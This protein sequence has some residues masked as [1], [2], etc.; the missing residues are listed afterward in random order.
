MAKAQDVFQAITD[1]LIADIEAGAADGTWRMPW[2]AMA[3]MGAPM[4][5]TGRPYR[6]SNA[7]WLAIEGMD[8]GYESGV[9]GTYKTWQSLGCQVRKGEKA[10]PI[11]FWKKTD[12]KKG[13]EDQ[14]EDKRK[15]GLIAIGF[16][17]F[18]SEQV[19]GGAAVAERWKPKHEL[20]SF[21]AIDAAET[22]FAKVGATV[23]HGGN[24][25]YYSIG[26]DKIQLP[27]P[28]AFVSPASYYSTRAHETVH[29]TGHGS[30]L[31]RDLANRFGSEKYAAEEMVAELGA[32]F[33][34]AQ[35]GLSQAT[36]E[37]HAR[38]LASWLKVLREDPRAIVT[39]AS[40]AQ[41]AVDYLNELAGFSMA[42]DEHETELAA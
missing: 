33:W 4:S 34:S 1:R 18:A 17:V 29:W 37:D 27:M 9:W 38:Y 5:A 23:N 22:Y 8:K 13:D 21:Q 31:E 11:T 6:G 36:R 35:M 40:K 10:T 2:H 30:R 15:G 41:A 12:P 26:M 42:E 19:D 7:L 28:E 24:R 32:A 14:G 3:E 39:F 20:D 16:S 25:A